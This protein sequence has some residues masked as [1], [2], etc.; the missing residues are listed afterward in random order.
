MIENVFWTILQGLWLILFAPLVAGIMNKAKAIMQGR[1]GP[2]ILQPY[3]DL[4]K[5]F[6][7]DAL[8]SMHISWITKATPYILFGV[9][10]ASSLLVPLFSNGLMMTGD[11]L[12]FIY[13]LAMGRFFTALAALDTGSSFG[14][15]GASRELAL[16]TVIEPAFLL[17]VLSIIISAGSTSFTTILTSILEQQFLFSLPYFLMMFAMLLVILGEAGKIPID[18]ADTHLELTMIHDGMNLEYSGRYY[19]LMKLSSQMKQLLFMSI[20]IIIFFPF[21]FFQ[22]TNFMNTLYNIVIFSGKIIVLGIFISF[23]EMVYA[24]VRLYQVPKLYVTSMTFSLLAIIVSV[25]F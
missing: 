2:R 15:M 25:L 23:I 1:N 8:F 10:L 7:K 13:L 12:L 17:A 21:E 3:Y 22:E 5:Y 24:K 9:T 20:F 11:F 18:N 16:N 14:G 19:G 6:K 4:N